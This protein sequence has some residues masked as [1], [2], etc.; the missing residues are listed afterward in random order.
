MLLFTFW[1]SNIYL[2][3][4]FCDLQIYVV[5]FCNSRETIILYC[6]NYLFIVHFF[7]LLDIFFIYIWNVISFLSSSP[8]NQ[9]SPFPSLYPCFYRVFLYSPTHWH[10]PALPFR[11]TGALDLYRTKDLSFHWYPT[12][13]SS[14]KY[15]ARTMS[16]PLPMC[17]F[18][19]VV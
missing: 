2:L 3:A 9:E 17:T 11:Y 15:V 16:A 4:I 18:W 7:F 10:L 12:R 14:A 8:P 19:L 1:L 5:D 6:T 13:P